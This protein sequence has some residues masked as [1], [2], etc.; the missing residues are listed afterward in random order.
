MH[1]D[2]RG[3]RHEE[4]F[5]EEDELGEYINIHSEWNDYRVRAQGDTIRVW[6]NEQL[7]HELI[8]ESPEGEDSGIIAFQIHQGP[9]M[10]VEL[11][12]VLLTRL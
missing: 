8:D 3:E 10:R 12:D 11:R 6:I 4:R 7:M 5:A 9:P 2:V 1:V